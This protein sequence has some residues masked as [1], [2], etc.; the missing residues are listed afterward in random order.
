MKYLFVCLLA[1]LFV[2]VA[3]AQIPINMSVQKNFSYTETF[4][5]IGNWVFNTMPIN[6]TFTSGIGADAWR[7]NTAAG[8]TG[9]IPSATKIV[10]Q[11][12]AFALPFGS[13]T[14]I[15]S[16]GVHKSSNSLI[17]LATGTTDNSNSVAMDF[18]L[19]FTGVIAGTFS[20]DWASL[21][22][23]T[24][25]RASSLRIYTSIDGNNFTEL[26]AAS[27]LNFVNT[28]PTSGSITNIALPAS[29]NNSP[30]AQIRFYVYNGT[31]GSSGPRPSI[32]IDNVTVTALAPSATCVTP[33]TQPTSFAI[34]IT[35]N[36]SIQASFVATIPAQENYMVVASSN[37]A[38]SSNPVNGTIYAIG[39]NLG[40]GSVVAFTHTPSFTVTGLA[41]ST[42][43]NFFIFSMKSICSAGPLYATANPLVGA[44]TTLAG[45]SFCVAPA[46]QPTTLLFSST[47]TSTIKG[48]FKTSIISDDYLVV[49]SISASLSS[50]PINKKIYNPGDTLGGGIVV[51]RSADSS[52]NAS[53]LTS[54]T[55]YYFFIFG[56]TSKNCNN[57]P[58]Y[59]T[60][61][62]LTGNASTIA[63]TNCNTPAF[64]PTALVVTASNTNINGSFKSANNTDEYLVLISNATSLSNLP[65]NGTSYI[66]GDM[67]GNA[68]VVSNS[69]ATAFYAANLTLST[70]Y[71]FYI[72]SKNSICTNGPKY[73]LTNP[74][75]GNTT[76][77]A[78]ATRNYYFGNLH[79]HSVF[80]DGGK[81]NS[82]TN[83]AAAYAYAK[84]SLCMDYLGV[85][86]HNHSTAG[87][88]VANWQPGI[89]QATAATTAN[90]LA[91]YGIEWGVIGN[92]G[93]V[94]VYGSNQL[95]GWET[96][97]YDVYV[98]ISD[99]LSKVG[100]FR[101]VNGLGGN[102]FA[103]LAHPNFG[104]YNNLTN[105]TTAFNASA[106]SA[107]VGAAV[108]SGPAFS[109]NTSYSDPAFSL[110]YYEYF[111]SLLAKGYHVGPLMDHDNHNTTFGRTS[112]TRTV[113]VAPTLSQNEFLAAMKG[114]HFYATED[115]DTKVNFVLNN[116]LMGSIVL[117]SSFPAISVFV[118]D[119]TNTTAI[120]KIKIMYGRPGSGISAVAI[121]S[122]NTNNYNFTDYNVVDGS[123]SYY[124]AEITIAGS[125]IITAPVWYTYNAVLPVSL[126]DFKAAITTN[127]TVAISWATSAE[128]NNK[129]FVV[130]KSSD[131]VHFTTL[132]SVT[133]VGNSTLQHNYVVF[134][135][136]PFD[137]ITYYRLQQIDNDGK[138]T[139]S[140]VVSV[141]M[142]NAVI[143]YFSV[144]PNPVN[145]QLTLN[146][147]AK[148][149]QK[150]TIVITDIFGRIL[151][152][153][154][155]QLTKGNQLQRLAISQLAAGN[156]NVTIV[157]NNS[158]LTKKVVKL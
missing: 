28:T 154:T 48:N 18:F 38:L 23:G 68:T 60:N 54:G 70:T 21:N 101:T 40:D 67:L 108:S 3:G 6:G 115:C 123:T 144:F 69:N 89:M 12:T 143:N 2:H 55:D 91:L 44:G 99:Y 49:R 71:Y 85:S 47:N 95:L 106:D 75:I 74:L 148:N 66:V 35:T 113:F 80:S 29:F 152:T 8:G 46:S 142:N 132:Q 153:K 79:S 134:D 97:N 117:G 63:L 140:N 5:D 72:F 82:S 109:T 56:A 32:N 26:S 128:I 155:L 111:K 137:G 15:S 81:D 10:A 4:S 20:Y 19:D 76:T 84:N 156:Y 131:G 120:A 14:S 102:A 100:L 127:K 136:T 24:G 104:D 93:H 98:P 45:G 88:N 130:E 105:S 58:S 86:E 78:I 90:F 107:M 16:S 77:T 150:A 42:T 61:S 73:L 112:T 17:M 126:L 125:S 119:P 22:N 39:D 62:P 1:L 59:N 147:N 124:F 139:V 64:Q 51:A 52:F 57:G 96:G 83:P 13:S 34:D 158:K 149:D 118:T 110:G 121:D 7:G 141:N 36:Y 94:L 138:T 129:L 122:A 92:G 114:R 157:F 43:Y 27:T 135:N 31:G 145:D 133:G 11:T 33:S 151:Q 25:N 9:T 116:Q 50:Q 87:M 103:T 30:T 53:G 65:Q 41:P 37:T 146:V